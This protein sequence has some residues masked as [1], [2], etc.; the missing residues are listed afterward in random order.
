MN[1][2]LKTLKDFGEDEC[3]FGREHIDR[4]K[5]KAESVKWVKEKQIQL[6]MNIKELYKNELNGQIRFIKHFFNL[7]SEDLKNE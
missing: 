6:G 3:G 5:L 1:K 4:N 2:E 7:T